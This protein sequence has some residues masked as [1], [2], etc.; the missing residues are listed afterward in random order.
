M[1]SSIFYKFK[2]SKEPERIVFDGTGISVFELKREIITAS[3]LGDGTDFDLH[4][5]PEDQPT[6]E[7]DDD[8]TIISR[9]STVIAV[10]RPAARGHGRA[11]R[12]VSGRAPV[13]AIKK[14]DS[15]KPVA[16]PTAAGAAQSEADAEAAFLAESAQ[17]WDQ[18]KEALSHAKPVFHKKKPVN[19]PAHEPPP[20]YVC[21]R[22]NKKGHWIQACPTND[23][24]DFKP[25]P[26]AKRTTGIPRSFLKTVE[27]PADGDLEDTRGIMLNAE[28]EYVQVLTDT[29]AWEK[30]QEKTNVTKAQAANADAANKEMRERGLECPIDKRMFVDPVK[31]PCCGKTYC[32]DCIENALADGDLV[33][34]NC[35]KDGVLIDDLIADDEMGGKIRAF[36]AEKAK[37]KVEKEQQAKEEAKAAA[38]PSSPSDNEQNNSVPV[39]TD[40]KAK[41]S[42]INRSGSKSPQQNNVSLLASDVKSPLTVAA[43]PGSTSTPPPGTGGNASDTDA[44][45][46]SKKR[47]EAPSDIKPP[48]APKAMRMQ[49]EQEARQTQDQSSA[50]EKNFFESMEAL[51][52]MPK[53][54]PM[55]NTLPMSMGMPMN[56]MIGNMIP[57][58][59]NGMNPTNNMNGMNGFSNMSNWNGYNQ[60]Y[61]N[62]NWGN[63]MGYGNMNGGYNNIG[64]GY[65]NMGYGSMNGMNS[66]GGNMGYGGGWN[67]S[68]GYGNMGGYQNNMNSTGT[69]P[70][71]QRT[72]F[73]EQPNDKDAYE[74]KPLNPHRSQNKHR[75]QRAPDFHYV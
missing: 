74:R 71:Q 61:P 65:G 8:T 52:N 44:S 73:S 46:T 63:N 19:V 32:H 12:Y 75:K 70:N 66:I 31:T 10:R 50:V 64:G 29:R 2:N 55:P 72:V 16:T 42:E 30:F 28:G 51:K 38:K 21:Y 25:A 68:Q 27:K 53:N 18:Q 67:Q 7:Y 3:G 1:S 69:F 43:K 56:S 40:E 62:N 24:P 48:T 4:L 26:R 49:K 35:S 13:R 34:P 41:A 39:P 6:T 54:M 36:E 58:S 20:A 59:M 15:T 33:C 5:Y 14:A 57:P 23:D 11:A 45:T 47:K 17:A 60:G 37:D 22:C 9:S